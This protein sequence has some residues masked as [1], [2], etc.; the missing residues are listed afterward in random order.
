[1]RIRLLSDH[2][3]KPMPCVA[4]ILLAFL[5]ILGGGGGLKAEDRACADLSAE[6]KKACLLAG[7][8]VFDPD[9]AIHFGHL[10]SEAQHGYRYAWSAYAFFEQPAASPYR[11]LVLAEVLIGSLYGQSD[12]T[13]VGLSLEKMQIKALPEWSGATFAL[14]LQMTNQRT[15]A[16][17]TGDFSETFSYHAN[18]DTERRRYRI[19]PD[20]GFSWVQYREPEEAGGFQEQKHSEALDVHTEN[21]PHPEDKFSLSLVLS[22]TDSHQRLTLAGPAVGHIPAL[23]S[24]TNTPAN[25]QLGLLQVLNP[26]QEGGLWDLIH[27]VKR[28]DGCI[29]LRKEAKRQFRARF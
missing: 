10:C 12:L 1:M 28:Y 18:M 9:E 20:G 27:N 4:A 8:T 24:S 2:S 13:G 21:I 19:A 5:C 22:N 6:E 7:F 29:A 3:Y 25:R 26:F 11:A 23:L 15:G 16:V 14:A 17:T